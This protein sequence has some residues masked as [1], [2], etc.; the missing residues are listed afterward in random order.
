MKYLKLHLCGVM[1]YYSAQH[2]LV[3]AISGTYYKTEKTPTKS[4]VTGLIGAAL[5]LPR[6][7]E[8]LAKLYDSIIVK[9]EIVKKGSVLTDFQTVKPP[10]GERFCTV[11]GKKRKEGDG[12]IK[13]IEYL[14]DAEFYVYIGGEEDLLMKISA[15]LQNPVYEPFLGKKSCFPSYPILEDFTLYKQE[16]IKNVYDCP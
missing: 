10:K 8:D 6:K 16:D 1:Q 5:G 4:A 11:E 14:Q 13:T 3:T 2:T 9:Y 15:A 7:S 12:I